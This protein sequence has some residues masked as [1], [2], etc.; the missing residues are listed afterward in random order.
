[1]QVNHKEPRH[2]ER[3][4]YGLWWALDVGHA[5]FG[6]PG[7]CGLGQIPAQMIDIAAPDA[8]ASTSATDPVC[9]MT[10][11]LKPDTRSE[12]FDGKSFHFC[13][14]K[15]QTRFRAD[16]WFYANGKA[17]AKGHDVGAAAQ[18]TCPMHPQILRDK[19]GN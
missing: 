9:G 7:H 8:T 3:I 16:P 2:D 4:R 11:V 10:V 15:C 17:P 12:S 14:E 18:Y 5:G 19:P 6:S 1:M 13:S